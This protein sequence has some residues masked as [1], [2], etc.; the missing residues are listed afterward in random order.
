MSRRLLI[1]VIGLIC[2]SVFVAEPMKAFAADL[3]E[4][5]GTVLPESRAHRAARRICV[6]ERGPDAPPYGYGCLDHWVK[7]RNTF[8]VIQ[9]NGYGYAVT[10]ESVRR[11]YPPQ[12]FAPRYE[13]MNPYGYGYPSFAMEAPL[14]CLFCD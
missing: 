11:R 9:D 13:V 2:S 7:V 14:N 3:A 4:G 5:Y 8:E 12:Y 6:E 10:A 1:T